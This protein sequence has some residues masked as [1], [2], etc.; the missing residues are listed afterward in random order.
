MDI[1]GTIGAG[2]GTAGIDIG[3][4]AEL[5]TQVATTGALQVADVFGDQVFEFTIGVVV[6]VRMCG[7]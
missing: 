4:I 7:V 5:S 2:L 6:I 1:V 3:Q